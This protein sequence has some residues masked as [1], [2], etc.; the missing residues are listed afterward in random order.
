MLYGSL[1]STIAVMN[2]HGMLVGITEPTLNVA[3]A[4]LLRQHELMALGEAIIHRTAKGVGK[5]PDVLIT[6]NGIKVILEGKFESSGIETVLEKQCVERIDDGLCEICIG[7]IYTKVVYTTLAPTMKEVEE[8]LKKSKF[9]ALVVYLAPSEVQLK[10]A[11]MEAQL[12]IGV[13]KNGWHTVDLEELCDLV[14]AS[15]TTVVSEDMLGKA[16]NS[17][18]TAL[19]NGAGRLVAAGN[20]VVLAEQISEIMEIPEVANEEP[21]E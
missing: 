7:I 1:D 5:K 2:K 18:A 12:P 8:K 15:Y 20:P 13:S 21:E 6:V 4:D 14:R 3:L 9:K 11:D 17:F 16:V 10:F 19:Q